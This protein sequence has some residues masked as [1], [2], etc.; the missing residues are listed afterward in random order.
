MSL[1]YGAAVAQKGYDCKT[2][3]DR[4]LVY[5]SAFQTLKIFN[6]YSVSATIPSSGS[7]TITINH[8]LG[9]YA[10]YIVVYNGDSSKGVGTSGF[11]SVPLSESAPP[12]IA[13]PETR[14]YANSLQIDV[15]EY[16]GSHGA[17]IYF[18][19]YIFLDDFRTI[20]ERSINTGTSSGSS[21]TDYGFRISKPGYDV[22]TCTDDQCVLSSSFFNQIIHKKGISSGNVSHNL[23]YIPNYLA[24]GK[25]D[26]ESYISFIAQVYSQDYYDSIDD[27]YLYL[28][29]FPYDWDDMYYIIFKNQIE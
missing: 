5:S 4:F 9:Y 21:S 19:V 16:F 27:S 15:E 18:T 6:T 8:N 24:Y 11:F 20:S 3:A 22:K 13:T 10:P 23:G 29:P 12:N 2:C 25:R 17:T 14:Q 28:P 1:D 26:G 7:T